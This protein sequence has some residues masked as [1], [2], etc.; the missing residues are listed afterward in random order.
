MRPRLACVLTA[1]AA[2]AALM[3]CG[4]G[5]DESE[6]RT[7]Q[8][9]PPADFLGIVT[10]EAFG[11]PGRYRDAQFRRQRRIGIGI[12]RQTFDWRQ[13]E[14]RPGR[15]SFARYDRFVGDLARRRMRV[16]P[17]L[18]N[19]PRF[20]S[21]RPR[22]GARRGT[23]PPRDPAAMG[24]FAAALV[25]RYGP[26]GSF[27]RAKPGLPRLPVHS[28]QVWNEPS[29][30][31]YWPSGPDPA[32]YVRLLRATGQAI[33]AVDPDA[34]ILSAGLAQS[35]LGVPFARFVSGMYEAGAAGTFDTFALHAYARSESGVVAAV[36]A[37]RGRI[38]A[39]GDRARIWVTEIGWASGGPRSPFTVGERG[40][41]RLIGR[42]IRALARARGRLG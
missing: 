37:A 11:R 4:G 13:I 21:S 18:F 28:W 35:R 23:Y 20:H 24:R 41:A 42:M 34:E 26:E 10:E 7:A 38:A 8:P 15:F 16:L 39:N 29:I 36:E 9:G 1:L 32:A 22:R 14:R 19:P 2:A 40:Q 25:R 5:G 30:P 12:V 3:G 17:V 6:A 27:W 31:V 33:K